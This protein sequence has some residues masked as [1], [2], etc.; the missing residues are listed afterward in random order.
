[1]KR[2]IILL[3]ILATTTYGQQRNARLDAVLPPPG[4]AGTVTL[5]LAEHNRLVELAARKP[6]APDIPPLPSA[7]SAAASKLVVTDQSF[8]GP[9]T[10]DGPLLQRGRFKV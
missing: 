6:P 5:S 9:V 2:S 7:L 10:T 3:L 8:L 1:M 4:S